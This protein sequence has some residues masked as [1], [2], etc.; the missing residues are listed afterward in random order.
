MFA[1]LTPNGKAA[2]IALICILLLWVVSLIP[3]LPK[4]PMTAE[5]QMRAEYYEAKVA[6]D[7]AQRMNRMLGQ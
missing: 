2:V 6:L 1:G 4:P 5:E 3:P 7:V